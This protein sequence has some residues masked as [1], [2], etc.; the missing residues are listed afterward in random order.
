MS[1]ELGAFVVDQIMTFFCKKL[2]DECTFGDVAR[3]VGVL[4]SP[5]RDAAGYEHSFSRLGFFKMIHQFQVAEMTLYSASHV[6]RLANIQCVVSPVIVA[7][8]D[9]NPGGDRN[10]VEVA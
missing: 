3:F 8:K 1:L 4:A 2:S 10:P 9:I 5:C 7:C 6:L